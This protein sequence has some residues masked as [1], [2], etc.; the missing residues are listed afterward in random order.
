MEHE[1]RLHKAVAEELQMLKE[2]YPDR[3]ELTLDDYADYWGISRRFAAQH[4]QRLN[5]KKIKLTYRRIGRR[6]TFPL[7][8]FAEF[9]A[10]NRVEDGKPLEIPTFERS[11][12]PKKNHRQKFY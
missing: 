9:L 2:R 6:F 7:I 4:L 12:V 8:A 1:A 11:D 3:A 5:Q 10:K